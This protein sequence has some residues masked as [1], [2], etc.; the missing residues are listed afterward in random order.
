MSECAVGGIAVCSSWLARCL[1]RLCADTLLPARGGEGPS[2]CQQAA[3]GLPPAGGVF[4]RVAR[5]SLDDCKLRAPVAAAIRLSVAWECLKLLVAEKV[6]RTFWLGTFLGPSWLRTVG[7]FQPALWGPPRFWGDAPKE[8]VDLPRQLRQ[9]AARWAGE[10]TGWCS[11]RRWR[12]QALLPLESRKCR[13]RFP[14]LAVQGSAPLWNC[15]WRPRWGKAF[16]PFASAHLLLV[17]VMSL[18]SCKR[19]PDSGLCV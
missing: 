5:G 12:C 4:Q 10:L 6:C 18:G 14:F 15:S 2:A 11:G 9:A 13:V 8:K 16:A 19:R 17:W 7:G 3:T 1:S